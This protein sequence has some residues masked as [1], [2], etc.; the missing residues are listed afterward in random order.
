MSNNNEHSSPSMGQKEA[1]GSPSSSSPLTPSIN[2]NDDDNKR[3]H[4]PKK[5]IVLF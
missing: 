5:S 3:P 4:L 2:N 1:E